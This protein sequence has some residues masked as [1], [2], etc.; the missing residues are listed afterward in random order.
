MTDLVIR[1]NSDGCAYLTLNRPEKLNALTVAMFERLR[2]H[3]DAIAQ[4]E[5]V[6][7]VVLG[8]SGKCFSAGHDLADIAAGEMPPSPH[9]QSETIERLAN[10]PQPVICAIH[11]HCYTG[12][13]ELALAGDLL[14]AAENARMADTH[15]KWGLT[16]VWGL[17][18]RLPRRVGLAKARQMMFTCRTYDGRAAAA[19]GLADECVPDDA[20]ERRVREIAAEIAA[21]SWFSHRANKRLLIETDGLPLGAGLAQEGY[22]TEGGA[23]DALDR[24]QTFKARGR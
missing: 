5:S 7:V 17:S 21:H 2:V 14:I 11:G 12:G 8:G 19:M 6:G 3:V 13:L 9:F 16:P 20:F 22:R 23:P 4:V 24:L 10:L 1:A 15:A 18:Q